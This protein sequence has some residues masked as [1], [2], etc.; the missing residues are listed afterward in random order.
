MALR[1]PYVEALTGPEIVAELRDLGSKLDGIDRKLDAGF[2]GLGEKLDR[3]N[4]WLKVIAQNS[5][6]E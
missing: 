6:R 5:V 3:A 4:E 1:D 2:D